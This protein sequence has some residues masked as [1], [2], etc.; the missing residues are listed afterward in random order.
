M[1][2][3]AMYDVFT[4]IWGFIRLSSGFVAIFAAIAIGFAML[5]GV[6]CTLNI[7]RDKLQDSTWPFGEQERMEIPRC[8]HC[9]SVGVTTP[10][11]TG[12]RSTG[13]AAAV[14]ATSAGAP[15]IIHEYEH[16]RGEHDEFSMIPNGESDSHENA[17]GSDEAVW[18]P[19]SDDSDGDEEAGVRSPEEV[20]H[21]TR[22][23][24]TLTE[25]DRRNG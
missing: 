16:E 13:N 3:D 15:E 5:V 8:G 18:T 20:W 4:G 24:V 10:L 2:D 23:S 11:V 25:N 17:S 22:T 19:S 21:S 6:V 1:I 7:C 12:S 9:D 14:P